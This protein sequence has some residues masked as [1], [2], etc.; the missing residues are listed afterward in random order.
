MA[1]KGMKRIRST[2]RG[3]R[4]DRLTEKERQAYE[5]LPTD[6]DYV[7]NP[8]FAEPE[9]EDRLWGP[10][11]LAIEIPP[12]VLYPRIPE[13]GVRMREATTISS[14]QERTLFLRY[15]HAKYRLCRLRERQ[16]RYFSA[17]RAREMIR[18][19]RRAIEVR[20]QIVHANLALVPAMARRRRVADVEFVELISE[21]YMAVLRS[22]ERFDVARG[23]KFSTYACRSIL[24]AFQYL[25]MKAKRRR[26]VF[27][28]EFDPAMEKSDF[29]DRRHEK[30][31]ADSID[32]VREVIWN[33][34]AELSSLERTVLLERFPMATTEKPRTLSQVGEIVGLSNERVRQIEK[35]S[36]SKVRAAL[37]ERFVA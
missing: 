7:D 11:S 34:D 13:E 12:H 3:V 17:K 14:E 25:G 35:I 15:N 26:G 6:L 2:T 29:V 10:G 33:N 8:M 27:P 28:V 37:E 32:A 31:R 1:D 19:H 22:V 21:G 9:A 30:Q 23:Y 36:L 4:A 24:S 20:E 18:W 5:A 16:E